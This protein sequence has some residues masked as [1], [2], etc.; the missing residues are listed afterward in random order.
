[1]PSCPV[2]PLRDRK[3]PSVTI[4]RIIK[5]AEASGDYNYFDRFSASFATIPD[6]IKNHMGIPLSTK[7]PIVRDLD[8]K[9]LM[10][11]LTQ[12][13]RLEMDQW[14]SDNA[15]ST[16]AE[17]KQ[18]FCGT[19]HCRGGWAQHLAGLQGYRL[20]EACHKDDGFVSAL[21]YYASTGRVPNFYTTNAQALKSIVKDAKNPS[22]SPFL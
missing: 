16:E 22:P 1:M 12:N 21:I 17:A 7:V 13:N 6:Y 2:R 8:N 14:H 18:H 11:L 15:D 10:T 5:H 19:T 3:L 4:G 20:R 9:L